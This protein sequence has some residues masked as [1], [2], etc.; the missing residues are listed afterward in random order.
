MIDL[1]SAF[2]LMEWQDVLGG[3]CETEKEAWNG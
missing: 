1:L 3:F 2:V